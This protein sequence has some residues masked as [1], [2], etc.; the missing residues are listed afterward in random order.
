M[1]LAAA[2]L[3]LS[4]CDDTEELEAMKQ[5]VSS[6]T[7]RV[8]AI[9]NTK[10]KALEEQIASIQKEIEV[11]QSADK[12][13]AEDISVLEGKLSVISDNLAQLKASVSSMNGA[14]EEISGKITG[15]NA[16]LSKLESQITSILASI[17][18]LK[19]SVSGKYITLSYIPKYTDNTEPV[20][21]TMNGLKVSGTA[22]LNFMVQPSGTAE[23]IAKDWKSSISTI[24]LYTL[25]KS[26]GG[27]KVDL[28][29]SDVSA[30]DDVLS[31]KLNVDELGKDF[32]LGDIVATLA[33]IVSYG[34]IRIITDYIILYPVMEEQGLIRYLLKN[35][36]K[37]RDCQ[38]EDL[39]KVKALEVSDL[40]ITSMD[41]VLYQMPALTTLKCSGNNLTSLDLSKNPNLT[42]LY[43]GKN[44]LTSLDLSENP[45]LISLSCMNNQ[46]TSLDLSENPNLTT[47]LCGN[48]QLTSLDLSMNPNLSK[49]SLEGNSLT[50]LVVVNTALTT[51][52]CR[53][54]GLTS[55][56]VSDNASLT[57]LNCSGNKLTSLDLSK[58]PKLSKVSLEGNSLTSLAVVNTALTTLDCRGLGLT[59]LTVSDNASLTTLNCNALGLTSLTLSNNA[60]LT[61][62]YCSDN[63]LTTIDL[64]KDNENLSSV[65]LRGNSDLTKVICKSLDW[66]LSKVI[67][68][69][70]ADVFYKTDGDKIT[71]DTSPST[72]ID[73]KTWKQFN[74]GT[75]L[76]NN[77]GD[78]YGF[79]SAKSACPTGW[80]LP[81]RAELQSLSAHYSEWTTNY[82]VKGRWFSGSR[83]YSKS[84]PAI[85]LPV[86]YYWS[87]NAFYRLYLTSERVTVDRVSNQYE[88]F[89]VRCLKE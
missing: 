19:E 69:D 18:N 51:L 3:I 8:A 43:C 78:K 40:G 61:T 36:D 59:S 26:T 41:D 54:L 82:G 58:N 71:W 89:Y 32:I 68:T 44:Q 23:T 87:A 38:I 15:I 50:S 20:Q 77:Y 42:T 65:N 73:G 57:T 7:E 88:T 11:L 21:Y 55:L 47:L 64:S 79:Y 84:A 13:S 45:N 83:T 56:T 72:E 66:I 2:V 35:F 86:G 49:V 29:V 12:V 14:T 16:K 74:V 53:G 10:I 63:A 37:D 39:D 67:Y 17:G 33:V 28:P 5:E 1:P 4:G 60:S 76:G 25:T 24:A 9:E 48:N 31:I 52:Y 75:R 6:L 27:E 85:F 62:L 34:D 46:L 22:T 70:S 80:R 81:T 30:N